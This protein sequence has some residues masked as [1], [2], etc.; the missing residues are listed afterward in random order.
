MGILLSRSEA[1]IE[2]Q[3]RAELVKIDRRDL[4]VNAASIPMPSLSKNNG[5]SP[6]P[7]GMS[8]V[9]LGTASSDANRVVMNALIG[10]APFL[11]ETKALSKSFKGRKLVTACPFQTPRDSIDGHPLERLCRHTAQIAPKR[12]HILHIGAEWHAAPGSL[13]VRGE[14]NLSPTVVGRYR[15]PSIPMVSFSEFSQRKPLAVGA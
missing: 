15:N 13:P 12:N 11:A 14:A 2:R 9:V 8:S 3:Y 5:V 6:D 4:S 10:S 1:F 7:S